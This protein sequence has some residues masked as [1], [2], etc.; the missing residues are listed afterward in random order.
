M[1]CQEARQQRARRLACSDARQC[2]NLSCT[3]EAR[4]TNY[5]NGCYVW[6]VCGTTCKCGFVMPRSQRNNEDAQQ[7][8]GNG[9][10]G[11]VEWWP[12]AP[13]SWQHKCWWRR[14]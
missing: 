10:E 9:R 11:A 12:Q 8:A 14:L 6:Y 7:T 13:A 2:S 4:H 3:D 5:G 1:A